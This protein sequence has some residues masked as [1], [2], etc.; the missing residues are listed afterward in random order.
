M[1]LRCGERRRR[2]LGRRRRQSGSLWTNWWPLYPILRAARRWASS[3]TLDGFPRARRRISGASCSLCAGFRP[4]RS[5]GG[6]VTRS[7]VLQH[8]DAGG[9]LESLARPTTRLS[10]RDALY[11]AHADR[12]LVDE[13]IA[14]DEARV[15]ELFAG[16]PPLTSLDQLVACTCASW[17]GS[18]FPS[19]TLSEGVDLSEL[20]E[21]VLA[22]LDP[23]L[24]PPES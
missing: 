1:A 6:M 15:H 20:P 8:R 14:M 9:A 2:C 24:A 16:A 5:A 7:P 23:R 19:P 10:F 17:R 11:R 22:P 4:R 3:L 12:G 18:R 13:G 21:R